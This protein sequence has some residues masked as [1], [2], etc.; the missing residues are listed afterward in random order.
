MK[1][2]RVGK[3]TGNIFIILHARHVVL[4]I[5]LG[6]TISQREKDWEKAMLTLRALHVASSYT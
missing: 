6:E 5:Q 3:Y 4:R 2:S 1:W